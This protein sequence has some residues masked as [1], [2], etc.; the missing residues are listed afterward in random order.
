MIHVILRTADRYH[1][2]IMVGRR[3]LT[4]ANCAAD[5]DPTAKIVFGVPADSERCRLCWP[6]E[7]AVSPLRDQGTPI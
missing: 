5:E 3:P 6:P 1:K 4:P 2:A 7:D